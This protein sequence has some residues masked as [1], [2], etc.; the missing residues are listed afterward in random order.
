MKVFRSGID[1]NIFGFTEDEQ[2][3]NLPQEYAPWS[4]LGSSAMPIGNAILTDRVLAAVAR[5]GYFISE[6]G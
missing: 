6:L 2:G 5:D 1:P 4:R 3:R